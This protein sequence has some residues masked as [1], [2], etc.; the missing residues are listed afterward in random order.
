MKMAKKKDVAGVFE[1]FFR[2]KPA[3]MLVAMK[4]NSKNNYASVLSK[5]IDCTYS[6]AVKLLQG[7]ERA[8]LVSFERQGRI[9]SVVLTEAGQKI[10]EH[11]SRVK[12]LMGE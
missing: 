1:I 4:R 2:E 11:I 6:H 12:E 7:M 8:K 5:D 3:E 9:K 10:A